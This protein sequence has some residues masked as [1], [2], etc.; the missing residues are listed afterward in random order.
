MNPG[1]CTDG[2][3][4]CVDTESIRSVCIRREFVCDGQP[5]CSDGSDEDCPGKLA[6]FYL[7][8]SHDLSSYIFVNEQITVGCLG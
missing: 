4:L 1:N 2:G 7:H 8:K 5:D 6:R 3:R